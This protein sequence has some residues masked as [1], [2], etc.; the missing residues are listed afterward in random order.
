[1]AVVGGVERDYPDGVY[2]CPGCGADGSGWVVQDK[3]PSEF[4]L[5]SHDLYPMSLR[6]FKK[7]LGVLTTHFSQHRALE[8]LGISWYPGES[9]YEHDERVHA[10]IV[11]GAGYRLKFYPE[12]PGIHIFVQGNIGEAV[13]A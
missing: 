5:Q 12:K 10:V 9:C 8:R 4:L 3:S 13:F 2:S 11:E 7:W 6:D 1:V